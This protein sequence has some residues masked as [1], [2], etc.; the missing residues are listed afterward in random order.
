[1]PDIGPDIEDLFRRASKDYPL[2]QGEDKWSEIASKING[3]PI[4]QPAIKQQ[5]GYKKYFS[6]LLFLLLFLSLD[7]F[8]SFLFRF[9]I[10]LR[11]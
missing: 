11:V 9:L 10:K 2:K 6:I 7:L 8:F 3:Q 1:M 5:S 4:T